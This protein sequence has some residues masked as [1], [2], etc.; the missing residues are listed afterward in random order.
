MKAKILLL[1]AILLGVSFTNASTTTIILSINP[2][3]MSGLSDHTEEFL[4]W[5]NDTQ[6]LQGDNDQISIIGEIV[7]SN[8]PFGINIIFKKLRGI[9]EKNGNYISFIEY[10]TNTI[11]TKPM[12]EGSIFKLVAQWDDFFPEFNNI[13]CNC[14]KII[15]QDSVSIQLYTNDTFWNTTTEINIKISTGSRNETLDNGVK[16]IDTQTIYW[17]PETNNTFAHTITSN[18]T[19]IQNNSNTSDLNS[20]NTSN[21][22]NV[23]I[24]VAY[25]FIAIVMIAIV[26]RKRN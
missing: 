18:I 26:R 21:S 25:G 17:T 14:E 5:M 13:T 10:F 6:Q 4:L 22:N 2:E 9:V 16:F 19:V 15:Y 23:P 11:S 7:K 3:D 1:L 24:Q 12:L 8:A 20:V